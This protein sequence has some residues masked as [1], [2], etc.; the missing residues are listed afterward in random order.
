MLLLG[1]PHDISSKDRDSQRCF[2]KCSK[3]RP[4]L[5][6]DQELLLTH[7]SMPSS[8]GLHGSSKGSEPWISLEGLTAADLAVALQYQKH[9]AHRAETEF[10]FEVPSPLR[11]GK[12][13]S[14]PQ[15]ASSS[16]HPV[17]AV[18]MDPEIPKSLT[19]HRPPRTLGSE[20]QGN[21]FIVWVTISLG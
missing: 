19:F 16:G 15:T 7:W 8:P 3:A 5:S 17:P 20:G 14:Y 10:V 21:E 11:R 13:L 4:P 9:R 12:S 6:P 2:Q 18:L 1:D